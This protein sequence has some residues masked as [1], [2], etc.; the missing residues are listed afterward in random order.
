MV[1]GQTRK[2]PSDSPSTT[3]TRSTPPPPLESSRLVLDRSGREKCWSARDNL[4]NCFEKYSK[5][6]EGEQS[7][8]NDFRVLLFEACPGSW[9]YP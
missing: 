5:D 1:E 3:T 9:V 4:F 8:C 7:M 2:M 6:N